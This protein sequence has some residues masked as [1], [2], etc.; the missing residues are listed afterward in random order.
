[1][2]NPTLT[3][4][5]ALHFLLPFIVT[6]LVIVHLFYLHTYGSSN[7]LG[8]CA[9]PDSLPFHSYYTLKDIFGFIVT[10]SLFLFV[11]FF[12]PSIFFEADNFIPANPIITPTHIVPEW[13]FLYAYAILRSI[14]SKLGG[15]IAIFSSIFVLFLLPCTQFRRIQSLSFYGPV[16]ILFW[17]EVVV[18]LLLIFC[19]ASPASSPFLELSYSLTFLYFFYFFIVGICCF[20]WDLVLW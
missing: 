12:F 13:Y 6:A 1:V 18:F 14:S 10:L 17:G 2:G 9:S 5:F 19:G 20:F 15:V 7:P 11:V 4:F 3:R 16:K 8:V